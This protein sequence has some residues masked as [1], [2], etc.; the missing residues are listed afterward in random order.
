[1]VNPPQD[2]LY[3]RGPVLWDFDGNTWTQGNL[4]HAERRQIPSSRDA[5]WWYEVQLEPHEQHWLFALDYPTRWPRGSFVTHDH[6]LVTRNPVT[7]LTRYEIS[8][9]PNFKDLPDELPFQSKFRSL[10]LPKER[11]V[12]TI[13]MMEAWR[14]EAPSDH[15]LVQKSLNYFREQEFFYS[16]EAPPLGLNGVDEFLFDLR[17]GYCEYY[18]SAFVVMMRA[19]DIPARVVTGYLGGEY[20]SVGNYLLVRQ[21]D[22]HAWAEVWIEGEGWIRVDPTAMVSPERVEYGASAA[23]DYSRGWQDWSWVRHFQTSVDAV[24]N[25]W[26]QWVLSF[27]SRR[28]QRLFN[29][30]GFGQLKHEHLIIV[31]I[32]L[33]AVGGF[34][35]HFLLQ[36]QALQTK[37]EAVRLY[38]RAL[39][40]LK[41]LGLRKSPNEG[42]FEFAE[43]IQGQLSNAGAEWM[44]ITRDYYQIR[45]A[46]NTERLESLRQRCQRFRPKLEAAEKSPAMT[47]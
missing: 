41:P 32:I 31:L 33:L 35:L 25:L 3:W 16:L 12:R 45:Y 44:L 8:T 40:R 6:Q 14:Q 26:N 2:E 9:A 28:Q 1:G 23:V 21:S 10:R 4:E 27:D 38:R 46:G 30:L 42:P 5:E 43:R 7:T 36:R 22:A 13:A 24:R 18:A 37:E 39:R 11:N 47:I 29:P 34:I 19:A 15:A 20:N 17:V